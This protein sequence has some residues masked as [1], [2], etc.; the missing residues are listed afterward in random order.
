MHLKLPVPG[1]NS[2]CTLALAVGLLSVGGESLFHCLPKKRPTPRSW[3]QVREALGRGLCDRLGRRSRYD[4]CELDVECSVYSVVIETTRAV[5]VGV[6]LQGRVD[7]LGCASGVPIYK[8]DRVGN[9]WGES[10]G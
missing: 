10:G 8:P 4:Y 9:G 6:G 3:S 7:D 5:V 1:V 2:R